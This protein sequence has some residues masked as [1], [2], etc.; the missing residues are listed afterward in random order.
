M[1]DV[2]RCRSTAEKYR[3]LGAR[4]GDPDLRRAYKDLEGLWLLLGEFIEEIRLS[5][6]GNHEKIFA[7]LDRIALIRSEV[8][9]LTEETSRSRRGEDA[10]DLDGNAGGADIVRLARPVSRIH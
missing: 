8:Q 4:C 5:G 7:M 10:G 3:Q 1:P 9:V 6:T 2:R